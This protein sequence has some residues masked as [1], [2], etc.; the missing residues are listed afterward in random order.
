MIGAR[1]DGAARFERLAQGFE[2]RALKFRQFVEKQ[3]AVVRQRNFSGLGAH[4]AADK[5]GE[6]GR[7]VR[8]AERA[9]AQ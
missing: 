6:R 2:R 8:I 3:Y 1:D 9:A 5:R 4:A 7:M